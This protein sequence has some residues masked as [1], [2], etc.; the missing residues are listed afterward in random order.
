[1][2]IFDLKKN[3]AAIQINLPLQLI[4]NINLYKW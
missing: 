3:A 4:L 1:M 2:Y